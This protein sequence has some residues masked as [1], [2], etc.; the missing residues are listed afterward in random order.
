MNKKIEIGDSV[1][2]HFSHSDSIFQAKVLYVPQATG[3]SWQLERDGNIMYVQMFERMD[4]VHK[5]FKRK[6][7]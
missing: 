3:D 2:I 5:S 4:L 1:T 6:E 7:E